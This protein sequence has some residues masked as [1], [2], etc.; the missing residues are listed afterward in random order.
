MFLKV[1]LADIFLAMHLHEVIR[2][3]MYYRDRFVWV[4]MSDR[5]REESQ[6]DLVKE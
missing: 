5:Q 4:Q 3:R 1:Y 6:N 2:V